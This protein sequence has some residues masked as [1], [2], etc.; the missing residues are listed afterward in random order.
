V[1]V[2]RGEEEREGGA[3]EKERGGEVKKLD[4]VFDRGA[5]L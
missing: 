3:S 2:K 5:K 1:E 4:S